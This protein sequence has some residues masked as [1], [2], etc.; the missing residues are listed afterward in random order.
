MC[1]FAC[2]LRLIA[3]WGGLISVAWASTLSAHLPHRLPPSMNGIGPMEYP[4]QVREVG[5][6]ETG[7]SASRESAYPASQG[8]C[9]DAAACNFNSQATFDDGSC[10]Y[11]VDD[12]YD[13]SGFPIGYVPGFPIGFGLGSILYEADSP[14]YPEPCIIWDLGFGGYSPWPQGTISIVCFDP[15]ACNFTTCEELTY[16]CPNWPWIVECVYP[17][18]DVSCEEWEFSDADGDGVPAVYEVPACTDPL[19]CNY[20]PSATDENG[21]CLYPVEG[22]E[23]CV[24]VD[25]ELEQ[26]SAWSWEFI[27]IQV[28]QCLADVNGNGVCDCSE[29]SGCTDEEACNFDPAAVLGD[30]SCTYPVDDCY[31]CNGMLEADPSSGCP[32]GEPEVVWGCFD[33]KACNFASC[34]EIPDA[35]WCAIVRSTC[36]Y[37]PVGLECDEIDVNGIPEEPC[38][39]DSLELLLES[40]LLEVAFVDSLVESGAYCG[41][42]T[43]WSPMLQRCVAIPECSGDLN[44]DGLVGTTDLLALL[45]NYGLECPEAGCTFPF[46]S[47]Y[48]PNA[49]VENSSCITIGCSDPSALNYLPGISSSLPELCE[50]APSQL[51]G[52]CAGTTSVTYHGYDYP[53]VEIGA[54]CWFKENLRTTAFRDGSSAVW[55]EPDGTWGTPNQPAVTVAGGS[56]VA[57][58]IFGN[59][60]SWYA[61]NDARGICPAGFHPASPNDWSDAIEA[62]GGAAWAGLH[63]RSPGSHNTGNG[64]WLDGSLNATNPQGFSAFPSGYRLSNGDYGGLYSTGYFWSSASANV[65]NAHAYLISHT[66]EEISTTLNHKSVGLSVRCVSDEILGCTD[67]AACNFNSSATID[68][69]S[70][71]YTQIIS[72]GCWCE[73]YCG[74]Q[75]IGPYWQCDEYDIGGCTDPTACNFNPWVCDDDGSCVYPDSCG[76]CWYDSDNDGV[77]GSGSGCCGSEIVGCM[78]AAA[79]NY[80]FAATDD[81]GSCLFAVGCDYCSGGAVVNGDPDGDG[82]CNEDE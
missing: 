11:P 56:H 1:I 79:C 54:R 38:S 76:N 17:P 31:D 7:H 57:A 6:G 8:G 34:E 82:V 18:G 68:S 61:V 29:P 44:Q 52:A 58:A 47:N 5:P 46:A 16:L 62:A 36:V 23:H 74:S 13:C 78:N 70:C 73:E 50:F 10:T 75:Y 53:V 59:L 3:V 15:T 80:N 49:A 19:A 48:N 69:G 25:Y 65:S 81:D 55:V 51:N 66:N 64:L 27:S 71:A 4:L 26:V 12:C 42:G 63:L 41:Q 24:S 33:A 32:A 9:M 45:S 37:A 20:E 30:G 2:S 77:C 35:L 39:A 67:P 72:T 28:I 22:C 43:L 40:S 21:S 60:Y 14:W